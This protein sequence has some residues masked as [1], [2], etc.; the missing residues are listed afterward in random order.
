MGFGSVTYVSGMNRHPCDRNRP[1]LTGGEAGIRTLGTGLSPYNG[2]ANR[3][4]RPLS[5]LTARLQVYVTTALTRKFSSVNERTRLSSSP[6]LYS[7]V[8]PREWVVTWSPPR[9]VSIARSVSRNQRH[10]LGVQHASET[11]TSDSFLASS[12]WRSMQSV[13]AIGPATGWST[14]VAALSAAR[15]ARRGAQAGRTRVRWRPGARRR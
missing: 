7:Q 9:R 1:S 2:L 10:L 3:R 4:F 6:R 11:T 12:A 13:A 5:H 14:H 8:Q 15:R